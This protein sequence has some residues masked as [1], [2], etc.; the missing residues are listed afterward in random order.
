MLVTVSKTVS[1]AWLVRE[2]EV[3]LGGAGGG[4]IQSKVAQ[5]R[6]KTKVASSCNK[7][8]TAPGRSGKLKT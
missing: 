7:E 5:G 1:G 8:N 6:L 3:E 4:Y 2:A